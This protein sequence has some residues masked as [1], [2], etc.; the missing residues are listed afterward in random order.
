MWNVFVATFKEQNTTLYSLM[1]FQNVRNY[2]TP[3][4]L[5]PF[6]FILKIDKKHEFIWVCSEDPQ[7]EVQAREGFF[8]K[9]FMREIAILQ[10]W[11]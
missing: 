4:W 5:K 6:L 8:F 2:D 10:I 9:L 1:P 11:K 7:N 3:C